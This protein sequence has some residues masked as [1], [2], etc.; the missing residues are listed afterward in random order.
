LAIKRGKWQWFRDDYRRPM[1]AAQT[2]FEP[3][4]Q[5]PAAPDIVELQRE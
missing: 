1:P 5:E 3:L 2:G 4:P